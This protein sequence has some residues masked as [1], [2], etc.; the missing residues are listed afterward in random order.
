[1]SIDLTLSVLPFAVRIPPAPTVNVSLAFTSRLEPEVSSAV[2]EEPSLI[3]MLVALRALVAIVNVWAVPAEDVNVRLLNS[4]SARLAPA[5]VMVP[6]VAELNNML[7]E[8]LSQ[9]VPSVEALVHVPLTVQASD[10]NVMAEEALLIFTF[11]LTLALPEVEVRSP[12][13][14]VREPA[15][16]VRMFFA[17]VP[18]EIVRAFVTTQLLPIVTVP[19][20]AVMTLMVLSVDRSVTVWVPLNCSVAVPSVKTEPAPEEFQPVVV[21]QVPDVKVSVP[22]VP[23]V[24]VNEVIDTVEAFAVR[25]PLLSTETA[26]PVRPKSLVARAVVLELSVTDSVP[27][28]TRPLVPIVKVRAPLALEL[29]VTLLNSASDRFAPAKV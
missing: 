28:Q 1:M 22:D 14:M 15:V 23:P 4:S 26:P 18:P 3:V 16:T 9:T 12:P 13:D 5:K 11:P 6:P 2:V 19:L 17:S 21:V 8:P 25:M 10:P 27:A 7:P 29:K 20:C 24:M